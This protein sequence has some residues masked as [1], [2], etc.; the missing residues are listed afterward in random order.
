MLE[1]A[2]DA[3]PDLPPGEFEIEYVAEDG[4]RHKTPL[5]EAAEKM[6]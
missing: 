6:T 4:T 1:A 5:A 3:A 2:R